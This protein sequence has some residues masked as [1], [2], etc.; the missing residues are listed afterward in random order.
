[1]TILPRRSSVFVVEDD[2][3][4]RMSIK[5]LLREHGFRTL[6]FSSADALRDHGDFGDAICL[7]IDVN[8]G[9]ESGIELRRQLAGEGV[10]APVVYITGNDSPINR[11]AA[12]ES[13]CVA[14]LTKPFAAHSLIE[15]IERASAGAT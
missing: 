12:M 4:M 9:S 15:S 8:L 7:V 13:G 5:R 6:L 2:A 1:L 14:Y 3:L 11:S 10:T